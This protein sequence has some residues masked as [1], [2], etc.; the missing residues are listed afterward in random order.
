MG[1]PTAAANTVRSSHA[2]E[3]RAT[4]TGPLG[5]SQEVPIS[6]G[7]V[8]VDATSQVRR[9]AQITIADPTLWPAKPTDLLAPYGSELFVEY[10]VVVTGLGTLWT[11]V[12]TGL[13][14]EVDSIVPATASQGLTISLVDRSQ[15]VHDDRAPSP[16]Q[17]GGD[18][19]TTIVAAITSII[20]GAYP[21]ATVIDETGDTTQ[22][23]LF[24]IQQEKW[25]DGVEP[26]ATSIGAECFCDP[27]GN[28]VIRYQPTLDDPTVWQ[29]DTGANGILIANARQRTRTAVYNQVIVLGSA[30]DGTTPVLAEV[31]D[32]DPTSPTFYDG[33]FGHKPRFF[34]SPLVT[35]APQALA[36]ATAI[37]ARAKGTDAIL[38]LS[39]ITNPALDAGNVAT[40]LGSTG[41]ALNILDQVAIPLDFTQPQQ[42][43]T[44][45]T[46]LPDEQGG[47]LEQLG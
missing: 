24:T 25:S 42:I 15:Y 14:A 28:F 32:E 22:C 21:A 23:A 13:L 27:S 29:V 40:L 10:G 8:N 9:T 37:L 3:L 16:F 20:V 1:L 47:S 12:I 35:S 46:V 43:T 34:S 4:A 39:T 7:S 19:S 11:P 44:H 33:P 31:H 26:L 45:A 5:S 36:A 41:T 30:S 17:V 6:G 38:T 18:G 2:I